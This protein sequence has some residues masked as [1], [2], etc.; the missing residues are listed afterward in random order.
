MAIAYSVLGGRLLGVENLQ[1]LERQ[2]PIQF[3]SH[4]AGRRVPGGMRAASR[5][6]RPRLDAASPAAG[7]QRS[8][9]APVTPY[10]LQAWETCVQIPSSQRKLGSQEARMQTSPHTHRHAGRVPASTHPRRNPVRP[11]GPRNKP[12]QSLSKGPGCR[13]PPALVQAFMRRRTWP[14]PSAW[15]VHDGHA[16]P[17]ALPANA[18]R[19][20]SLAAPG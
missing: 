15:P 2:L 17:A 7:R 18:M 20:P 16:P 6:S 10:L 5:A 3:R 9:T 13:I 1:G 14:W 12:V 19:R 8:G 4:Q 11:S